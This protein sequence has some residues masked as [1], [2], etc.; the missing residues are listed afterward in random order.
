MGQPRQSQGQQQELHLSTCGM[1]L[2]PVVRARVPP[3]FHKHISPVWVPPL[4]KGFGQKVLKDAFLACLRIISLSLSLPPEIILGPS[5]TA[6]RGS[7]HPARH[8]HK[9]ALRVSGSFSS[10]SWWS[11][12]VTGSLAY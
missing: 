1:M 4:V 7:S 11:M 6:Y 10:A 12:V 2:F 9:T 3:L 5:A 8:S